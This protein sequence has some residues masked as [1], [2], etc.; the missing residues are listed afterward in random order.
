MCLWHRPGKNCH[1]L[2]GLC[3]ISKVLLY[4]TMLTPFKYKETHWDQRTHLKPGYSDFLW[5][6]LCFSFASVF[7]F[8]FFPHRSVLFIYCSRPKQWR[9]TC[10]HIHVCNWQNALAL[11]LK[12]TLK[13]NM[14][15]CCFQSSKYNI[16]VLRV[17]CFYHLEIQS[18]Q[19]CAIAFG[20]KRISCQMWDT[21]GIQWHM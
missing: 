16:W 1:L 18:C 21:G 13:I 7:M 9:I 17:L 8:W 12:S 2:T 14:C 6:F 15:K 19:C 3:F 20:R 11:S 10:L 5:G 4:F